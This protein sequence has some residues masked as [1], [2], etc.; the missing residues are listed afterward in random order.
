M[1][2]HPVYFSGGADG[3][4]V[5]PGGIRG[6]GSGL[7]RGVVQLAGRRVELLQ[8]VLVLFSLAAVISFAPALGRVSYRLDSVYSSSTA[9]AIL[10]KGAGSM[11]ILVLCFSG[12]SREWVSSFYISGSEKKNLWYS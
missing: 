6:A 1:D 9:P 5:L 2:Q 10:A 11:V 4:G 8:P 12:S 3:L 7:L